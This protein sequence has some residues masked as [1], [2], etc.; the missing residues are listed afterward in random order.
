MHALSGRLTVELP[1]EIPIGWYEPRVTVWVQVAGQK[2]PV[3]LDNFGDNSNTQDEQ[4][5]PLVKVGEPATPRLPVVLGTDKPYRGQLG[6]L[7][8]QDRET[9]GLVGRAGFP[10]RYVIMPG[11]WEMGPGFPSLFPERFV[12]PV[13]GGFDVIPAEIRH[14]LQ[15]DTMEVRLELDGRPVEPLT[16]HERIP[17]DVDPE[18][19]PPPGPHFGARPGGFALNLGETGEHRVMLDGYVFDRFGRRFAF[20]GD[21]TVWT[22]MPLSFSTSVKPGTPFLVGEGYPAKA[23]VNPAFPADV[24]VVIDW[25]PN[26]APERHV[27]WESHGVANRFGHYF[28]YDTPGLVFDEPGEYVS[29]I[30][31]KYTDSNG[32]LWMGDQTSANVVAPADPAIH[33]HGTRSPPHNLKPKQEWMG[34]TQRF[35][36]RVDARAAFLPFKP[37]QIPD[38]FAPYRVEDTLLVQANGFKENIIEPHLSVSI[39]E[40]G[41]RQRVRQGN[42]KGTVLPPPTART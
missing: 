25:Y 5:L 30:T 19:L 1:P 8:E 7:S 2:E 15:A 17:D 27:R 4:L 12:A 21:Y 20:G 40:P 28:P 33:L 22:A 38:T 11:R 32:V 42:T 39:D 9:H 6:V 35:D 34:A 26:S 41:L 29:H 14:Y 13:D 10:K 18:D 23:K 24:D 31:A 16:R 36:G 3:L 37:G